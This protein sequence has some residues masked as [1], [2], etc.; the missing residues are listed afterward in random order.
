[1]I[2]LAEDSLA[3]ALKEI[4]QNGKERKFLESIEMAVNLKDVDLA[5]PKN[6][7]NE[8]IIL[9]NGRGKDT[10]VAIIGSEELKS[11]AK[12]IADFVYGP[13]DLSKFAED[14]KNF[15]KIA[16]QVDF[17]IAEST[18]MA[19]VGKTLG[20]VLG[21]RGK[22]PKPVPP[23]QDP[24]SIISNLRKTVRVRS[25]DR[26]TFH[27]LVGTKKMSDK[28]IRENI[29]AIMK[30]LTGKLEKGTGNIESVYIKSTM[31]KAVKVNTGDLQ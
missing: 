10:K 13:E 23:G 6:R 21:P 29:L 3:L 24:A 16:N 11:K 30:R 9:P 8:E 27:V 4:K 17:F 25:R 20:Q 22:I 19:T 2:Q 28:E 14:K 15:K 1:M 12:G 5:D 18:L 26:R 7:V 31:G